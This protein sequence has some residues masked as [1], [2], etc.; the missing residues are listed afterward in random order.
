MTA[1]QQ[2]SQAVWQAGRLHKSRA[3][4]PISSCRFHSAT[5]LVLTVAVWTYMRK[6]Y[7][8]FRRLYLHLPTEPQDKVTLQWVEPSELYKSRINAAIPPGVEP[9]GSCCAKVWSHHHLS[10]CCG[11]HNGWPKMRL[12][13]CWCKPRTWVASKHRPTHFLKIFL[14]SR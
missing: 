5:R 4:L 2:H 12:C 9:K 10:R 11:S 1:S 14:Q 3:R 6:V 7:L 13:N 8:W